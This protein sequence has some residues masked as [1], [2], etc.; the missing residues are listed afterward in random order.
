M[1]AGQSVAIQSATD[2]QKE[3]VGVFSLRGSQKHTLEILATLLDQ[4][5]KENSLFNLSALLSSPER[6]TELFVMLSSTLKSDGFKLLRLPDP[7]KPGQAHTV[8]FISKDAYSRLEK[9][10]DRKVL[11]DTIAWFIVRMVTLMSA[12][13]ASVTLNK[14]MAALT[15]ETPSGVVTPTVNLRYKNPTLSYDVLQTLASRE[16]IPAEI[17]SVF[18]VGGQMKTVKLP[19]SET[20]DIRSLV[21]FNNLDSVVIDVKRRIVYMPLGTETRVMSITFDPQAETLATA[22]QGYAA[23]VAP[24]RYVVP[25]AQQR[26]AAPQANLNMARRRLPYNSASSVGFGENPL[27]TRTVT[28]A[29]NSKGTAWMVQGGTRRKGRKGRKSNKTRKSHKT[30][31]RGGAKFFLVTLKNMI[32]CP[33]TGCE[34]VTFYMDETGNTLDT[35]TYKQYM[36]HTIGGIPTT[37]QFTNRLYK[38]LGPDSRY[39]SVPLEMA[40][41]AQTSIKTEFGSLFLMS[42]ASLSADTFTTFTQ[43]KDSILA[44]PEGAS[45]AQYRAFLLASNLDSEGYLQTLFCN[46]MWEDK[47]TTHS[48]SYALLNTLYFDRQEGSMET[49]TASECASKVAEFAGAK[50]VREYVQPGAAVKTFENIAFLKKPTALSAFCEQINKAAKGP[51]R[52]RSAEDKAILLAAHQ[53]LRDLYDDHL[54]AV[55]DIIRKVMIPKNAGYGNPPTLVLS[56]TFATDPR[57]ATVVLEEIIKESRNLLANHYLAVEKVYRG[58]LTSLKER[59]EGVYTPNVKT[60]AL[61]AKTEREPGPDEN[62]E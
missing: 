13:T 38:L 15:G 19:G 12:L 26:Y 36:A 46:D 47:R 44:A 55:V 45:P 17:M 28:T 7:S 20:D 31:Q 27:E 42:A 22:P 49:L 24:Q 52:T 59:V 29:P 54:K 34:V 21:Y 25:A 3:R 14:G 58:A 11:C 51:R 16:P 35:E 57:G 50:V 1:G 62:S 53:Q 8:S 6:C 33:D 40:A 48:V 5:L 39:A 37:T 61:R 32:R 30:S 43:V 2:A 60:L 9:A 4:L 23:P 10:N 56:D 41:E 18:R